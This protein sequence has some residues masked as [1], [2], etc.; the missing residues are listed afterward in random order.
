[1]LATGPTG[2]VVICDTSGFNRG[3]FCKTTP[4]VL[5]THTYVNRKITANRPDRRKF[6]VDW[7]D[8]ELSEQTRFALS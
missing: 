7:R 4:R 6:T 1:M 8:N 3:G 5:S 2:T